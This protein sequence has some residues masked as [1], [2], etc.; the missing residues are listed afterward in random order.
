MVKYM[1]WGKKKYGIKNLNHSLALA[2]KF[3]SNLPEKLGP[4]GVMES[5][6]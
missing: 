1:N 3:G 6:T 5:N 2:V 4:E